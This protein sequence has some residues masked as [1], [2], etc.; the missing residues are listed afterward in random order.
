V[1]NIAYGSPVGSPR[2]ERPQRG[3][4][5]RAQ[6]ETLQWSCLQKKTA[7]IAFSVSCLLLLQ[8]MVVYFLSFYETNM[9]VILVK[10]PEN[11]V[12]CF[13][14]CCIHDSQFVGF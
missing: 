14:K 7:K 1:K 12:S 10:S 4:H 9:F 3:W 13:V 11:D 6:L 5:L 2:D 8:W